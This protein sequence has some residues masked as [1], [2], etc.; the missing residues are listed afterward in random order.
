[1]LDAAGGPGSGRDGDLVVALG[2]DAVLEVPRD[3]VPAPGGAALGEADGEAG[4]NAC[5]LVQAAIFQPDM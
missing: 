2:Q 3:T 5:A 1:M 4:P